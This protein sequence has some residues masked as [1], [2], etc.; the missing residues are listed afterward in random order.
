MQEDGEGTE[1]GLK[2]KIQSK[3]RKWKTE[4]RKVNKE[5]ENKE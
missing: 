2:K 1:K 5:G 4:V 3:G